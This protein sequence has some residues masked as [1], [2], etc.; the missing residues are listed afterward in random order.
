MI[1]QYQAH[2]ITDI[3]PAPG[4]MWAQVIGLLG[5]G[6]CS[7]LTDLATLNRVH[8][9]LRLFLMAPLLILFLRRRVAFC[10]RFLFKGS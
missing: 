9:F 10:S 7:G 8:A 2:T 6:I 5:D 1:F 4:K 3:H